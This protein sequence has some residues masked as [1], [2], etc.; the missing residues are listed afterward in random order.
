MLP[1]DMARLT[2]NR[3]LVPVFSISLPSCP[4]SELEAQVCAAAKKKRQTL[5]KEQVHMMRKVNKVMMTL[6]IHPRKSYYR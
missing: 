5:G 4:R 2:L 6:Q 3:P 1:P